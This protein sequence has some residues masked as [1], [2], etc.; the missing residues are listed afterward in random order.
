MKNKT[1]AEPAYFAV[2]PAAG[3]GRRMAGDAP[4]QYLA[5]A[6]KTILEHTLATLLAEPRL[7]TLVVVVGPQDQQ[8]QQLAVFNHP[9]VET[10]A[11]GEQRCHSVLNGLN[12]LQTRCT[13]NDWVLVH[14]VARPCVRLQDIDRLLSAVSAGQDDGGLL[15]VPA[16]DTIKQVDKQQRVTATLDRS[17]LWQAQT[18]QMFRYGRLRQAMLAA[19]AD[20]QLVTDEAA[21]IE[22]SGGS[23]RLVEGSASNIK[24]T[25]AEDLALAEFYLRHA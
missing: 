11:G 20:N 23:V 1:V 15:A 13:E 5:I 17:Q 9:R 21:A 10:V 7:E 25:R 6:G 16:S 19:I 12:Y 18:P 3:I 14:D 8:W 4:K 2:I 24:V 22:L